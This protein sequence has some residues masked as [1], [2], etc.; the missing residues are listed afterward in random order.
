[1]YLHHLGTNLGHGSVVK[2][3][4]ETTRNCLPLGV[5]RRMEDKK[6]RF[7]TN[8]SLHLRNHTK[9]SHIELVCDLSN[10]AISSDVA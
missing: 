6:M 8:I 4:Y 2:N 3:N 10:G 1:M 9:Y 7:S 5:L